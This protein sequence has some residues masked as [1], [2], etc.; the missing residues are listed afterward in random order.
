MG[1]RQK[2]ETI[3]FMLVAR[4]RHFLAAFQQYSFDRR[5]SAMMF[6]FLTFIAVARS[7]QHTFVVDVNQTVQYSLWWH[8]PFNLFMW[9]N[10]F[11]VIPCIHWAASR[12]SGRTSK[13]QLWTTIFFFLPIVIIL[14]RQA[15]AAFISTSVLP[16][17]SDFTALFVWRLTENPWVWLDLIVYFAILIAL[18][19]VD[20][21]RIGTQNAM[22]IA[23]LEDQ[24]VRSQLNALRSQLHPHFLFNTLNTVSTLILKEDNAEAERMLTLLNDFL[25]TTAFDTDRQL[26]PLREEL[27][28]INGY[29]EIEKVRFSDKLEVRQ[30]IEPATLDALV[31]G[32]VLQPIIENAIY[33]AIAVKASA[34]LLMI[35][36]GEADGWLTLSV[37]DSG[38]GLSAPKKKPAKEG[39]GLK[40]TK[41]RLAHLYNGKYRFVV[42]NIPSGGVKASITIPLTWSESEVTPR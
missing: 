9:W 21:Q 25:T 40:I 27:Q 15:A 10:W 14:L 6:V 31:P 30:S 2:T 29:L 39:V 41:E 7:M 3:T 24:Y 34:G 5:R 22:K 18:Q 36:S 20:Y 26:I 12:L 4:T 1:I 32:F 42:E 28:F 37:E 8:V 19:V 33:H 23:Q 38:P 11:L 16:D 35:S 13:L 17:K